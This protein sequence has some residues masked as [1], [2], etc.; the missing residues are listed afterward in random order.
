[1]TYSR[2][3]KLFG[4]QLPNF[5]IKVLKIVDVLK[6]YLGMKIMLLIYLGIINV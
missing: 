6:K 5:S 4:G 1:M 3:G 2:D